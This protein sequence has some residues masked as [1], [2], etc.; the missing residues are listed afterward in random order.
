MNDGRKLI[1]TPFT[2]PKKKEKYNIIRQKYIPV[3]RRQNSVETDRGSYY[4]KESDN[5]D[6]DDE[7]YNENNKQ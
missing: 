7:N 5:S 1:L 2:V 3:K 4:N 6:N